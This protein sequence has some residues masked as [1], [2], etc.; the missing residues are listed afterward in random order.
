LFC[1]SH[2]I[3]TVC[4]QQRLAK[5]TEILVKLDLHSAAAL[6][7]GTMCSRATSAA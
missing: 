5:R 4:L 2:D 7:T 1:D 6:G 3:V